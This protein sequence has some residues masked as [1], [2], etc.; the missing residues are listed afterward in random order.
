MKK[1][2]TITLILLIG[3]FSQLNSTR[4]QRIEHSG[5]YHIIYSV[6]DSI[7]INS[8]PDGFRYAAGQISIFL[9]SD[10]SDGEV[11]AL[12]EKYARYELRLLVLLRDRLLPSVSVSFNEDLINIESLMSLLNNESIVE[13]AD[14]RILLET[15]SSYTMSDFMNQR[16]FGGPPGGINK[17]SIANNSIPMTTGVVD[18]G[19]NLNH[20][21]ISNRFHPSFVPNI[22]DDT[23]THGTAVSALLLAT[24]QNISGKYIYPFHSPFADNLIDAFR[25]MADLRYQYNTNQSGNKIISVNVSAG[26]SAQSSLTINRIRE[27]VNALDAQGVLVIAAAR[28]ENVFMDNLMDFPIRLGESLLNV[29]GVTATNQNGQ[30]ANWA[31]FGTRVVHLAAPGENIIVP[32]YWS[33]LAEGDEESKPQWGYQ[34]RSGT[35]YAAP[36]VSGAIAL[37]YRA[38]SVDLLDA[39]TPRE[40]AL[41]MRRWLLESVGQEP[42]LRDRTSSG[43]RLNVSNAVQQVILHN[44]GVIS[45]NTTW[46]T[47]RQL[48]REFVVTEGATLTITANV[49][50]HP[51]PTRNRNFGITVI[52]GHVIVV[53][54]GVE[55]NLGNGIMPAYERRGNDRSIRSIT[56]K[57][58]AILTIEDGSIIADD[59]DIFIENATVNLINRGVIASTNSTFD[60][61][62]SEINFINHGVITVSDYSV[63]NI[64]NSVVNATSRGC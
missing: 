52:S 47:P 26:I 9:H 19:F 43:G 53:G 30:F 59:K 6:R 63:M 64:H 37:M 8:H 41:R 4:G 60:V 27:A 14:Y 11:E 45:Q 18:R 3:V 49:T 35:S 39:H 12:E 25:R 36:F 13:G 38:A 16:A 55:F 10:V 29:I 31:G 54:D 46:D 22:N 56:F 61:I 32:H 1:I 34:R 17:L 28:N 33:F 58:N 44:G 48:D 5:G 62:N 15:R 42:T 24:T 51:D 2:L 57:D 21:T 50:P 20:V 40:M 23:G 7:R